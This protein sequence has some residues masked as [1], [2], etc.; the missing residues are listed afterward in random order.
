MGKV[1]PNYKPDVEDEDLDDEPSDTQPGVVADE[2]DEIPEIAQ[3]GEAIEVPEGEE[4]AAPTKPEEDKKPKFTFESEEEL[5][6]FIATR[7]KPT[8]VA[9]TTPTAPAIPEEDPLEKVTFWKGEVDPETGKWVGEKPK[10]WNDLARQVIKY[11]TSEEQKKAVVDYIRNMTAAE[12]KEMETID[13]E[14]DQEF[15]ALAAEGLVP[16]RGTKEGDEVNEKI[17]VIGGTYGLSSMKQAFELA[18]K[19]PADQGGLL[20]YKPTPA[21]KV[22]PSKEASRLIGSSTQTNSSQKGKTTMPYSKLHNAR[23]VACGFRHKCLPIIFIKNLLHVISDIADG[24]ICSFQSDKLVWCWIR[25]NTGFS[26]ICI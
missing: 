10:D 9:P 7:S 13:Q 15:D 12:K 21:K 24:H 22:N 6:K 25:K 4:P 16:K 8:P 18:K 11:V 17:S 26:Q 3:E 2:N 5:N 14:F 20:D 19:I 23:S 1:Q